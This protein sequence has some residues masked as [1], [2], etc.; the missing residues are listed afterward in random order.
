MVYPAK[1]PLENLAMQTIVLSLRDNK[2]VTVADSGGSGEAD[3]RVATTVRG[4]TAARE[5]AIDAIVDRVAKRYARD[6]RSLGRE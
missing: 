1:T 5:Q 3:L 2:L 6:L 4:T